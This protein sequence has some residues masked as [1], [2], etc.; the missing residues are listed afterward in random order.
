MW[1]W[2]LIALRLS[3]A[4][5]R[6][7]TV[8]CLARVRSAKRWPVGQGEPVG[9]WILSGSGAGWAGSVPEP[10]G[11][12]NGQRPSLGGLAQVVPEMPPVRHL[13]RLGCPDDGAFG[14]ERCAIAADHLDP[15]PFREPGGQTGCLAVGQQVHRPPAFD[16][17]QDGPVVATLAGRKLIDP[18]HPWGRNLGVGQSSTSR[19]TV[20]RLTVTPKTLASRAPA[21]PASARPTAANVD[22]NRSVRLP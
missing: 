4:A 5:S 12:P 3:P 10:A 6:S 8:A 22:R 15:R 14:E 17:D 19:S 13:H 20:L 7:W 1:S 11:S 2:R 9:S 16:I 18:D 21:R